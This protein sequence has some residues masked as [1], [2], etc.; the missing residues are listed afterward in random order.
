ML[1]HAAPAAPGPSAPVRRAAGL[2]YYRC[3]ALGSG[4]RPADHAGAAREP[5][6][7]GDAGWVPPADLSELADRYVLSASNCPGLRRGRTSRSTSRTASWSCADA[8][9]RKPAAPS[10][11]SSSSAA[12]GRSPVRSGSHC[13]SSRDAITADLADGVLTVV[14]PKTP[15]DVRRIDIE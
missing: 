5:V 7:P 1:S 4:A 9:P 12:R 3:H 2:R 10:G 6:R 14:V 15:P 11:I 8:G 13:R